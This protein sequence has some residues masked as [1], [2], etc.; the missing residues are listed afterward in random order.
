VKRFLDM[1]NTKALNIIK[2]F[3]R[4]ELLKFEKFLSSPYYNNNKNLEKLFMLLK[5]YYPEFNSEQLNK[6]SIYESIYGKTKF[7]EDNLR[8][9]FSDLYKLA[10]KFLAVLNLEESK[11]FYNKH[12]LEELDKRNLDNIY[13]SKYK[14][15]FEYLEHSGFHY[16]IFLYLHELKW[17]NVSFHLSRGEQF[18]LPSEIFSRSEQIIFYFLSD[19]FITLND[20]DANRMNFNYEHTN[21]LPQ[22]FLDCLDIKSLIKYIEQNDFKNKEIFM[23]YYYSFLMNQNFDD[24]KYFYRTRSLLDKNFDKLNKQGKMNF[25][26]LLI[27]YCNFKNKSSKKVNDEMI[28]ASIELYDILIKHELYSNNNSF[29]RTDIFLNIFITYLKYRDTNEAS[30]FLKRNIKAINPSHSENIISLCTAMTLFE[31][32]KFKESLSI[33]SQLNWNFIIFK[34]NLRKLLMKLNFE[35]NEFDEIKDALNNYRHFVTESGSISDVIKNNNLEFIKNYNDLL[36]IKN[37]GKDE[38][39][40]KVLIENIKKMNDILDRNWFT[41]KIRLIKK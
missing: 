22:K 15:A 29:F 1:T 14:E 18:S 38:F 17:Q 9:L 28:K 27:N 8:K 19:L 36:K 10:E 37:N 25:V 32:G 13:R 7:K 4:K 39:T 16:Q 33:A 40:L 5:K 31:E 26:I 41:K 21:N 12:L 23:L 35:L 2:S 30:S 34:L 11:I 3:S 24:E 20:I 6:K